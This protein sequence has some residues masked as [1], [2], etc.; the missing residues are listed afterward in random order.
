VSSPRANATPS[1]LV[2]HL[3]LLL[4]GVLFLLPFV[5]MIVTSLKPPSDLY[6]LTPSFIP[7]ELRWGNYAQVFSS[8]PFL[9]YYLNTF[10]MTV[11][12]VGVQLFICSMA[13]FA[14]ARLRFPGR[15]LLFLLLLAALMVPPQ[16]TII[17]NFVLM[18]FF[19]WIDTY[20]GLI[21]P[22]LFSAFG[23]F[24]LR[25]FFLTVPHALQE[26]AVLEGANPFQIYRYIFLPMARSAL[27]AFALIQILWSWNDFL[28][29]LIVT[30]SSEMRVLSVAI[31][32]FQTAE[33]INISGMMAAATLAT[34]PM[35]IV[36][37][38][39]QRQ[40]I[41]GISLSGLK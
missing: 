8:Q 32:L 14:F 5:W 30:G 37:L 36:F 4:V 34:V 3:A 23:T 19:G 41:E 9:R 15:D 29:P 38:L 31:A 25:Q 18:R 10:V 21:V 33:S 28:W 26:A 24:L 20:T 39:A 7:S 40:L 17:P 6:E 13:A 12:R 35:L 11:G 16:M 27:A 22:T 1:R 2:L